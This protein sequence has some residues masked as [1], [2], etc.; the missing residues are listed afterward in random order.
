MNGKSSQVTLPGGSEWEELDVSN[1]PTDFKDGDI[2]AV[3]FDVT[4]SFIASDWETGPTSLTIVGTAASSKNSSP[5]NAIFSLNP[6]GTSGSC[7]M[8]SIADYSYNA[9]GM[10][11]VSQFP[12]TNSMNG[13]SIIFRLNAYVFNGIS[14]DK[15][16]QTITKNNIS[17]Y[18]R[19]LWRLK[20]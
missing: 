14:M 7:A 19:K 13:S 4:L 2:I 15:T 8:V 11:W 20:K 17:N 10:C 1:L 9:I 18:I 5:F 12:S 3:A 6:A 16:D